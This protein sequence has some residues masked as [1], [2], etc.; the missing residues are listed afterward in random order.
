MCLRYHT[1]TSADARIEAHEIGL[2]QIAE[3]TAEADP[4]LRARGP[5]PGQRRRADHRARPRRSAT[6]IPTPMPAAPSCS[7]T[8][9][10]RWTRLRAR[11]PRLFRRPSRAR[12]WRS[13]GCRRR[14]SSARRAAMRRGRA[15]TARG[16]ALITSTCVDT[17]IWPKWA[18]PTLTHHEAI[19]GHLWQGSIVL[20][21][22]SIPLLHRNIGIA[23]LW[24]GL[25]PLC[26]AARRR[27][28]HVCRLSRSAGSA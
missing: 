11:M 22:Q 17:R 27:D 9:T 7:P 26:R 15:S 24:R 21:N 6:S 14:S 1:S 20:E 18:L 28:R 19:P 2:R 23:G 3:L 5:D 16:P 25:G 12:R 10:A 4:L 8:S 13:S